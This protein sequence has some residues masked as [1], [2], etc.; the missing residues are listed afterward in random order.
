MEILK[1]EK[2]LN[3]IWNAGCMSPSWF[4]CQF[5]LFHNLDFNVSL[6]CFTILIS[7]SVYIVPQLAAYHI[8]F[9]IRLEVPL[10]RLFKAW[11]SCVYNKVYDGIFSSKFQ[12]LKS[13]LNRS[14]VF[15]VW[16]GRKIYVLKTTKCDTKDFLE[17]NPCLL[18]Q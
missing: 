1:Y 18:G 15:W 5:I 12:E 3:N 14:R 13:V 8:Y 11:A 6:Y 2:F 17:E 16:F 10:P 4:Q 7:M 9:P